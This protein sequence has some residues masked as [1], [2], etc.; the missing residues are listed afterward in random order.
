M[1]EIGFWAE[2]GE[3]FALSDKMCMIAISTVQS[4]RNP[5]LLVVM[6]KS[7]KDVRESANSAKTF[8]IET[9]QIDET[10]FEMP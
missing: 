5:V 10:S 1:I 2:A 9:D 4:F 6:I 3:E 8:G 7:G